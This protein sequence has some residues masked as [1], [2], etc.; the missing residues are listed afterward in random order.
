VTPDLAGARLG[1]CARQGIAE[2]LID[3][4]PAWDAEELGATFSGD[5]QTRTRC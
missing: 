3:R 4:R 2:V 5:V 1:A